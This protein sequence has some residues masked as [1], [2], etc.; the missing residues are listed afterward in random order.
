MEPGFSPFRALSPSHRR[1]VRRQ[2]VLAAEV[3]ARFER[4][5]TAYKE[6]VA[7][8]RYVAIRGEL[9]A[10]LGE[11]LHQLVEVA[12]TCGRCAPSAV[13]V[14]ALND[15]IARP[16]HLLFLEAQRSRLEPVEDGAGDG[17]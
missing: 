12:K 5:Q 2:R 7:D 11:C 3:Q 10:S 13:R 9:D 16:L 14:Q 1:E 17:V 8:P 6:L 4:V 15:I